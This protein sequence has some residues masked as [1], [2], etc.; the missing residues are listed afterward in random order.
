M[1][2]VA[3]VL[4]EE[5]GRLARKE[6][7]ATCD[8]LRQQVQT[9]KRT[10]RTQQETIARLEKSLS[11]MVEMTGTDAGT[12]LYS[13]EAEKEEGSRARVTPTSI[14]R[15][16]HRLKMSQAELGRLLNVST[17]TIVRWEQGSS[18]PRA[19]HRT[20]LLRLRHMGI[21]DVKQILAE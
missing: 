8:P 10:V 5:I 13:P 2:N 19:Q 6:I 20:A 17:N 9:L 4:K 18:K 15:H 16:R 3:Q 14:R 12:S 1:P 21:R 11:K 7:R